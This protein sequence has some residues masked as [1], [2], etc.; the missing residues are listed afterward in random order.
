VPGGAGGAG[1]GGDAA[2]SD[3][4]LPGATVGVLG[5]GQ[6]GRMLALAARRMG[7]RVCTFS[8]ERDTPTGQVADREI[9]A[10]YDDLDA[11]RAFAAGVDV[12]TLEFENIPSATVAA[13]A[14][15][16]PVRPGGNVLH[17][18]QHRIREKTFL[19]DTGFPVTPFRPVTT[20]AELRDGLAA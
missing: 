11:I 3:P 9:V 2:V 7:Y 20:R 19:R 4:I 12:V 17:T 10:S 6:L 15:S 13:I 1:A 8:P 14:A 16:V 18:T 5:S